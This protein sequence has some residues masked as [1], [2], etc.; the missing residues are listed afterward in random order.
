MTRNELVKSLIRD[1]LINTKL[2][3]GLG[4]M[5]LNADN[6]L[7]HLSEAVFDLMGFDTTKQ[8]DEL[9][10]RYM[11]MTKRSKQID[12]DEMHC[13]L[14]NLAEEIHAELLMLKAG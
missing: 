9:T 14:E 2:V 3:Y 8:T 4:D 13:R 12:A 11:E 5:G 10:E 7:L 6:Y 1:D